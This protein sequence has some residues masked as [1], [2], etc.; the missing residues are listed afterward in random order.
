MAQPVPVGQ[1]VSLAPPNGLNLHEEENVEAAEAA[2][3]EAR[4]AANSGGTVGPKQAWRRYLEFVSTQLDEFEAESTLLYRRQARLLRECG[5]SPAPQPAPLATQVIMRTKRPPSELPAGRPLLSVGPFR[6][7]A[8]V[9]GKMPGPMTFCRRQGNHNA[10]ATAL[11]KSRVS[12][13]Y[14]FVDS[15]VMGLHCNRTPI[16]VKRQKPASERW[17]ENVGQFKQSEFR[18]ALQTPAHLVAS[19][20]SDGV[21][22]VGDANGSGARATSSTAPP[23][24]ELVRRTLAACSPATERPLS[25]LRPDGS[26][27]RLRLILWATE[28]DHSQW[29]RWCSLASS[30]AKR[31]GPTQPYPV[32][33]PTRGRAR[34]AHLNWQAEHCF[35]TGESMGN[36]AASDG[37]PAASGDMVTSASRL[38][39]LVIAVVEPGEADQYRDQ[40]PSLGLLILPANG[41][42][43]AF[44]RWAVQSVCTASREEIPHD[45]NDSTSEAE[46]LPGGGYI[47]LGP[48][49][50]LRFCWLV[51]DNV[52]CFY[53]LDHISGGASATQS[54]PLA[55][56]MGRKRHRRWEGPMF[57]QAFLS[58]QER[59]ACNDFAI[60]GF[61]RDDGLAAFKGR[62]WVVNNSSIFKIVL[63]NLSELRRLHVQ[64]LPQ[65]HVFED[66]CINAEVLNAGGRLLK[67]MKYCY[68]ASNKS[69]GGCADLRAERRER[70]RFT[71]ST[72]IIS[73]KALRALPASAR[74]SVEQVVAWVKRDEAVCQN[75]IIEE[76]GNNGQLALPRTPGWAPAAGA[77]EPAPSTPWAMSATLAAPST[78]GMAPWGQPAPATPLGRFPGF[79]PSRSRSPSRRRSP[80][81]G[82]SRSREPSVDPRRSQTSR[83]SPSRKRSPNRSCSPSRKCR[84][85]SA[86][87]F[88]RSPTPRRSAMRRYSP[89]RS[90]S[91]SR[92]RSQSVRRSAMRTPSPKRRRSHSRRRS[93]HGSR[94]RSRSCERRSPDRG[95]S[96]SQ[97]DQSRCSRSS[98]SP[99]SRRS[100]STR[101]GRS[102]T[103]SRSR[104]RSMGFAS[105][106][107]CRHPDPL[108]QA[109]GAS[110]GSR[111]VFARLAASAP[112]NTVIEAPASP[113]KGLLASTPTADP[114]QVGDV[115]RQREKPGGQPLASA[116]SGGQLSDRSV[117]AQAV[118]KPVTFDLD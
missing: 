14:G 105:R 17:A 4:Q 108:S 79:S 16:G 91:P 25:F 117:V 13:R 114:L 3:A 61:L 74:A 10:A 58:L 1:P 78:P 77:A 9:T 57:A 60:S 76:K 46:E 112:A 115:T 21:C 2:A 111:R 81:R 56:R 73:D 102:R 106:W 66:V 63:L 70:H 26:R 82:R 65:L 15:R 27:V 45:G 22:S 8:S 54:G 24:P 23:A 116:G 50:S 6:R 44:A 35:G 89:S 71:E 43:V 85:V 36:V 40:W 83:R 87:S 32:F 19:A 48:T 107:G 67:C 39:P 52:T 84:T 95:R 109:E 7:G 97:F 99:T 28:A 59:A 113:L 101:R 92:H 51:D 64:Y 5:F 41:L 62:D 90:R 31:R 69:E 47:R 33:I 53:R 29:R 93:S 80:S 104:G 86:P 38:A 118:K 110:S 100:P 20:A 55:R 72:D 42:G 88:E 75:R 11:A 30:T 37:R 98:P 12:A 18:I 34:Q 94:D 49:N 68:W 103:R 96:W